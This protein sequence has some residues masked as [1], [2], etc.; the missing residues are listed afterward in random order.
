MQRPRK[1]T[2]SLL[3]MLLTLALALPVRAAETS[4]RIDA[5]ETLP[6]V[7]ETFTVTV[8][9]TGNPGLCAAQYTLAFDSQLVSCESAQVGE[10]LSGT[11]SATNPNASGGAIVAAASVDPARGDGSIG[12]FTFRVLKSGDA[13]FTLKDGVFSG[14]DGETI[15]TNV[16]AAS[17]AQPG[18]T[19]QPGQSGADQS[20]P[21]QSKP[22]ATQPEA[23]GAEAPAQRFTD[24]SPAHWAYSVVE[25][26]AELGYITGQGDGTFAPDREL[27]RAEFVTML[28]R[29]AG[30]PAASAPAAF[31]DVPANAWYRDAVSWA[32]EQGYVKGT[33]DTTFAPNGKLTRQ[34]AV[35]V[36]FRYSGGQSGV[37]LMLTQVYDSQYTDSGSIADWAK[38]AVYWAIYNGVINGTSDTT[39]SPNGTATRAQIAAILVRYS[40]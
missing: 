37:E 20:K 30:K 7:G 3:L 27:T 23:P 8:E 32:A 22:D 11:L 5:P 18:Q 1:F 12:V 38:S 2:R 34:E 4:L 17:T 10:V 39:V 25:Q 33:G 15:A 9:I 26:A 19:Q 28:W 6:A 29:M 31:T 24:V 13:S 16:P 40:A 36:L 21:D 14:A 35:T